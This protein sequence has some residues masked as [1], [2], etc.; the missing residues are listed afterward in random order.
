M[1]LQYVNLKLDTLTFSAG[2]FSLPQVP[3]IYPSRVDRVYS[4]AI[5]PHVYITADLLRLWMVQSFALTTQA[6]VTYEN[7]S[8]TGFCSSAYI[9]NMHYLH[10]YS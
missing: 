10:N 2:G 5:C 1:K 9:I 8:G 7:P 4:G 6:Y 3:T